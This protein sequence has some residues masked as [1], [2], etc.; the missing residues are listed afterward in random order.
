MAYKL[1]GQP[2]D[3][4]QKPKGDPNAPK[5]TPQP[6]VATGSMGSPAVSGPTPP[7][8]PAWKVKQDQAWAAQQ[9]T[10]ADLIAAAEAKAKA[11][12]GKVG[13]F[14]KLIASQGTARDADLM[15]LRREAA[16]S[17]AAGQGRFAGTG[18]GLEAARGS[19]QA[20]AAQ[21]SQITQGYEQQLG[22]MELA[23]AAERELAAQAQADLATTK[24]EMLVAQNIEPIVNQKLADAK[25][26]A[27]ELDANTTYLTGSEKKA[28]AEKIRA[29]LVHNE[30][31]PAIQQAIEDWIQNELL[32][33]M[34]TDWGDIDYG[35]GG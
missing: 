16:R 5:F 31:N 20:A 28:L 1:P 13:A 30:P 29:K 34:G 26:M 19:A 17:L 11:A 22:Q 18:A 24:Q 10:A 27:A 2:T 6:K 23:K 35:G 3:P 14:D 21:G 25:A 32:A 33:Y 15:N 9:Q 7:P 12:Q 4:T 8:T